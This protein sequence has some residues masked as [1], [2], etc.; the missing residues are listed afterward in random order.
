V[1]KVHR[2]VVPLRFLLVL[3]FA[4]LAL[5]QVLLMVVALPSILE[6]T[7]GEPPELARQMTLLAVAVLGLACVQVVIVCTWKLLTL[8]KHDR[9]FSASSLPWVDAIVWA[10][11]AACALIVC[12]AVPVMHYAEVDDAPGLAGVPL[13]ML[14]VAGALGLLMVVMRA[15][16]LQA[17]TLRTDLEAV[18]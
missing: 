9:I 3:L 13:L 17:T 6:E 5:A 7:A 14:V 12:G 1:E 16:L 18:I 10:I 4:V 2:A 15:L 11:A 8:V